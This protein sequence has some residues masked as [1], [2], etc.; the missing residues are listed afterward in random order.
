METLNLLFPILIV[1]VF[2]FF[3]I[4]PQSQ[5]RKDQETFTNNLEK[6][7]EVVTS[8]GIIGRINKIEDNIITLQVD[9]KTFIRITKGAVSKE[10]TE[11]LAS[12]DETA[13]AK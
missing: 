11:S 9:T 12:T 4:R 2:Y 5:M 7:T 8:S 3:I 1:G 13:K 6:G 10:M